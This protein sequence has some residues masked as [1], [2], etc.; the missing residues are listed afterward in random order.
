[1]TR[2]VVVVVGVVVVVVFAS[3]VVSLSP[4]S[5]ALGRDMETESSADVVE[6]L[7]HYIASQSSQSSVSVDR[8]V[9][10][11]VALPNGTNPTTAQALSDAPASFQIDRV[12]TQAGQQFAHGSMALSNVRSFLKSS[13]SDRVRIMGQNSVVGD[14]RVATGVTEIAADRP[15]QRGLTGENVTV[16]IIDSD[17]RLSHPAIASQ[18]RGYATIDPTEKLSSSGDHGTAVASIV[19]DTAPSATLQLAA[20]G[21]TT[22]PEEYAS[23]VEW[24][25][26]SGADIIVDAGSYYAQPGDGTGAIAQIAENASS[27][28]VFLTSAG[29][30][31]ERYWSG[32]HSSNTW[33]RSHNG[34]QANPLNN[35]DPLSGSVELTLRWDGWPSTDVDY[36]L[37]LFRLQPG[38]DAVVARASGHDGR[39]FE[40]LQTSVPSGRYYVSIRAAETDT[41]ATPHQLELFA[42]RELRYRSTGGRTAPA[43]ASGVITVGAVAGDAVRSF[44]ARGADVVAPDSVAVDDTT[45]EGG[46]SVSTPYVAATAALLLELNPDLTPKQVRTLLFFTAD[47]IGSEGVDPRSGY[48]VVNASRAI[49]QT[50]IGEGIRHTVTSLGHP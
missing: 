9:E 25:K 21:S 32:N 35:G 48:G 17:F 29:N 23:A 5:F 20:V 12:S 16:G 41:N 33:V 50:I 43:T 47:D 4:W 37:Y 8:E 11:A 1:M 18:V 40:H 42:N 30:H 13:S 46:T 24:L 45:V 38:E 15:H 3:F 39:P 2:N 34:T 31:A 36:D 10:V 7:K 27:E 28:V 22:T 49:E 14:G 44:S 6:Q 26:R 19:V